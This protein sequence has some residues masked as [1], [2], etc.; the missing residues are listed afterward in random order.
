MLAV[1]ASLDGGSAGWNG[2]G[3]EYNIY[4]SGKGCLSAIAENDQVSFIAQ[5]LPPGFY[6][7]HPES[8]TWTVDA[9]ICVRCDHL[10]GCGTHTIEE[11]AWADLADPSAAVSALAEAIF[12]LA[13]RS[14]T[15]PPQDWR[16]RDQRSSDR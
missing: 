2:S 3:L 12:W 6:A 5:L 14:S 15:V 16:A 7:V 9:E 13:E 4:P 1:V 8:P 10:Q 11:R